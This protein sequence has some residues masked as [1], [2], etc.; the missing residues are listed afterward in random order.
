[1]SAL[2]ALFDHHIA[3]MCGLQVVDHIHFGGIVPEMNEVAVADV[4][5]G[6]ERSVRNHF[7]DFFRTTAA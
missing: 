1:M 2:N 7:H 4:L 5:E 3:R 6:V